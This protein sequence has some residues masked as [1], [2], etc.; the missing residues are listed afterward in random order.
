MSSLQK[1]VQRTHQHQENQTTRVP[2]SKEDPKEKNSG[3]W[4]WLENT[5]NWVADQYDNVTTGVGDWANGVRDS[6]NE[7]WDV[8]ESTNF[9]AKD[10]IWGLDTDL[11]ELQDVAALEGISLDREASDNQVR[12]EINRNTGELTLKCASLALNSLSFEGFSVGS[13]SMSDVHI[14]V[15]NASMDAGFLGTLSAKKGGT[16]NAPQ[17][18]TL[19][20]GSIVGHNI[21]IQDPTINDGQ[22]ITLEQISLN[23]FQLQANGSKDL[24]EDT[25][26]QA[27]FSVS[28]AVLQGLQTTQNG[29]N[30]GGN[31][32]MAG[33]NASFDSQSGSGS[34]GVDELNA[35]QVIAGSNRIENSQFQGIQANISPS[36]NGQKGH[37]ATVSANQAA[38]QGIDTN[39]ID[40][41]GISGTE[42]SAQFNTES[43]HL[44]ASALDLNANALEG[45]GGQI[46]GLNANNLMVSSDLDDNIHSGSVSSLSATEASHGD[47]SI[48]KANLT[49][50][51]GSSSSAGQFA[52]LSNGNLSDVS[53]YGHTA[54]LLTIGGASVNNVAGS[55]EVKVDSSTLQGY[56]SESGTVGSANVN[57][58]NLRHNQGHSSGSVDSASMSQA[59]LMGTSLNQ[60]TIE[61]SSFSNG[62]HGSDIN[63]SNA[64]A[65]G[66]S[67]FGS[68]ADSVS[69]QNASAHGNADLTQS[70]FSVGN[71][72]GSNL[73]HDAGSIGNI[74]INNIQG[75]RSNDSYNA[76]VESIIA[77]DADLKGLASVGTISGTN[78]SIQATIGD[79]TQYAANLEQ[80]ALNDVKGDTFGTT[81]GDA[82]FSGAEL[83][84]TDTS[85]MHAK[86]ASGEINNFAMQGASIEQATVNNLQGD[87]NNGNGDVRL[88]EVAF[89]NAQ[90]EDMLR[91]NSGIAQNL[92]T[93]GTAESQQGSMGS[94]Q[95]NGVSVIQP[96]SVSQ[97]AEASLSGGHFAHQKDGK[98]S[99]GVENVGAK[100]IQ[101]DITDM[102]KSESVSGSTEN[103]VSNVDFT[104]LLTSGARRLDNANI[105]AQV[106]LHQGSMGE[107]FG[108]VGIEN[109]TT[110][111]ADIN[112]ANNRIQDGS[113]LSTNKAL[114]TALFTSVKGGYVENGELKAD[115]RGWFDMGISED[116]NNSMGMNGEQLH[117][118]G[119]YA[120]A[121]SNMP[122]SN[123]N[124][125]A[126][127]LDMS[128]LHAKGNASLS[129]G[130]VSAGDANLT[131][132][133]AD[134]GSNQM[135]FE[136]THQQIAMRFAQLLASS[137]QL[138]TGLGQGQT[139][140]VAVDNGSFTVNPQKGTARGLVDSVSI[141]DVQIQN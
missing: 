23:D 50:L 29:S 22:A 42:L 100:E 104:E 13:V 49:N 99:I 71:V 117:S 102:D 33:A 54:D 114:D 39:S 46:Q 105:Q 26:N 103:P 18:V 58:L 40:A 77:N 57:G 135:E 72:S 108:S 6:A 44:S 31:I 41:A 139:G 56:Q 128:T 98:S 25:P 43:Q 90:Y 109:G 92:R 106:G 36:G 17:N 11:D 37:L 7:I 16:D 96:Q 12:M 121:F 61:G 141:S 52:S 4:G 127:P 74:S 47:T 10:G 138:N 84:G 55:Q 118:I 19:R 45:M 70:G 30:I 87:L 83:S 32:S 131:L 53:G 94:A 64:V 89:Q 66:V 21:Q 124:T 88:D 116:I 24:F 126:N 65:T 2:P 129:D 130:V 69:L 75:N 48:A 15:Q 86:L 38:V 137:F 134:A 9:E 133:G 80:L 81:I 27:S 60:A 68:Q 115:V 123:D 78:A 101:V 112:V 82:T 93:H 14:T 28:N 20:A 140:E 120:K 110:L 125:M 107:G 136:A 34:L 62:E 113:S 73:Q 79:Q 51:A 97:I 35:S 111:N 63:I 119:D 5:G 91:I 132:S 59:N 76:G 122:D 1:Q 3:M 8:V 67:G 95:V 85:S